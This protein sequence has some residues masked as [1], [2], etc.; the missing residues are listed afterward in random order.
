MLPLPAF[1]YCPAAA[2]RQQLTGRRPP[3]SLTFVTSC[4]L[5]CCT[6][7]RDFIT[8]QGSSLQ[9]E[10]Q[11]L[12]AAAPQLSQQDC[13]RLERQANELGRQLLALESYIQLNQAGFVKISK[14]HDKVGGCCNIGPTTGWANTAAACKQPLSGVTVSSVPRHLVY[15]HNTGFVL[16]VNLR[17]VVPAVVCML[18][19]WLPDAPIWHLYLNHLQRSPWLEDSRRQYMWAALSSCYFHLHAASIH[20]SRE[21]RQAQQ[22]KQQQQLSPGREGRPRAE[23]QQ[24]HSQPPRPGTAQSAA[25]SSGRKV[26]GGLTS[27][28]GSAV[29]GAAS[30][31]A[32]AASAVA[33]ASA[34]AMAAAAAAASGAAGPPTLAASSSAAQAAAAQ[35]AAA[36]DDGTVRLTRKFWV[37]E[38]DVPAV[39]YYVLQHLPLLPS[40]LHPTAAAASTGAEQGGN[41]TRADLGGTHHKRQQQQ[42]DVN[43]QQQQ[44]AG[45]EAQQRQHLLLQP[46]LEGFTTSL[47]T[48]Y[49]D[50]RA[51]Q[52]YHGRLFLRP[53]TQTLKARWIGQ[54]Q[55]S[56]DGPGGFG[57][58]VSEGSCCPDK[59]VLE[60][61][62]YR[63]GWR[64][65]QQQQQ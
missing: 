59:V 42:P 41:S 44:A 25:V 47:H 51:L 29:S 36:G 19:Q 28:F 11:S 40:T 53:Q 16:G 22:Q 26:V 56:S 1:Y 37:R 24:Q 64:G 27:A 54:G 62:V 31:V 12:A 30:A 52:L 48:V 21:R 5:L 33:G 55:L 10:L 17:C 57:G 58:G 60:R 46:S 43:Q 3:A 63:E 18:L 4:Q 34:A 39:M 49:F 8:S 9:A 2:W 6:Q 20:S 7:V 65:K 13:Q 32:G 50:N 45:G 38:S 23:E 35:A 61:K 15:N 14:K